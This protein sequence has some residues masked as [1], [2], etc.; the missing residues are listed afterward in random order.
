MSSRSGFERSAVLVELTAA[1]G[2]FATLASEMSPADRR[3]ATVG[4][5]WTNHQLLFHMLLGYLVVWPLLAVIEL[6]D[7][8][9][10]VAGRRFTGLLNWAER[11]FNAVNYW[12]GC[13]GAAVLSPARIAKIAG[14]VIVAWERR[15]RI[16]SERTVARTMPFPTRWDPFFTLDMSIGDLYRYPTQHFRFHEHQLDLV[17]ATGEVDL[18]RSSHP[19]SGTTR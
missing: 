18:L 5:R 8:L 4:T 6:F 9:P 11:P 7:R 13:V 14:R 2:R 16:S 10:P 12:G 15:V 19:A 3:R 1:R 17:T